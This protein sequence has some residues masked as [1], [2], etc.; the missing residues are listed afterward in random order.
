LT[1][2]A[3]LGGEPAIKNPFPRWPT[4]SPEEESQLIET[5]RSGYW[6]LGSG[7]IEE[8]ENR[9]AEIQ[10]ASHVTSVANGTVSLMVALRA[11]GVGYGDEVIIPPYTFLATASAVLWVGAVPVFADIDP[12]TFNLCPEAASRAITEKTK[13]IVP[14]H[15][16]GLP[17]DMDAFRKL[18]D[19]RGLGLVEDAAQAHGAKWNGEGAGILGDIGSFSFQSSKNLSGG[20]GGMLVCRDEELLERCI[21][22]KNCGRPS[23]KTESNLE[24]LGANLRMSGFQAGILL[25]QASRFAEQF[26]QREKN[27]AFLK[28]AIEEIPGVELQARDPRV[29]GHALH[30][31][32]F[33]YDKNEFHGLSRE[34]FLKAFEKEGVEAPHG[35][36]QPIYRNPGF[37]ADIGSYLRGL[38]TPDYTALALPNTEKVCAETSI[39]VRQNSLLGETTS[40][41]EGIAEA[42]KKIHRSSETLAHDLG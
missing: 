3:I 39:W 8:W 4:W 41:V 14:V 25:A 28:E 33:R 35:G 19:E 21:R 42:I 16:G 36:Y 18:A 31:L 12:T 17:C 34:G 15:I 29:D 20:E 26:K 32:I 5:L 13:A 10:G 23:G 1:Q 37:R 9:F 7:K 27:W 38:E 6:G 11:L 24:T 30:L 22:I 2:L 40:L